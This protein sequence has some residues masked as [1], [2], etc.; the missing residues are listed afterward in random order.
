MKQSFRPRCTELDVPHVISDLPTYSKSRSCSMRSPFQ[1]SQPRSPPSA[2][3]YLFLGL[4][5]PILTRYIPSQ[6]H[7]LIPVPSEHSSSLPRNPHSQSSRL[8]MAR[9]SSTARLMSGIY[10]KGCRFR[11]LRSSSV[12][13]LQESCVALTTRFWCLS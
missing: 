8:L 5:L 3:Q 12:L 4:S 1:P 6:R 11:A 2:P 7:D 9:S 10:V 13:H